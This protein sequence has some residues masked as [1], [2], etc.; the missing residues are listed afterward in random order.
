MSSK[1]GDGTIDI[2]PIVSTEQREFMQGTLD[3]D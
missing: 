2:Q 3:V 1:I